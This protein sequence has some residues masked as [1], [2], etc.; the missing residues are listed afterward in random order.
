MFLLLLCINVVV[1][2]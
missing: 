1:I 2:C